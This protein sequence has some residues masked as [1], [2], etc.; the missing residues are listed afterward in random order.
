ML[1]W[2][3]QQWEDLKTFRGPAL[4]A[5]LNKLHQKEEATV[6][7]G[8]PWGTVAREGLLTAHLPFE[9]T[10]FEYGVCGW[11]SEALGWARP[12]DPPLRPLRSV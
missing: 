5:L 8:C 2:F 9:V 6:E 3:W 10:T 4:Q 7:S 11:A 12:W 1:S